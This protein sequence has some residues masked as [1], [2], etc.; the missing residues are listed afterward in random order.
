M[1][2]PTSTA[3][4]AHCDVV[5]SKIPRKTTSKGGAEPPPHMRDKNQRRVWLYRTLFQEQPTTAVPLLWPRICDASS[6]LESAQ[7]ANKWGFHTPQTQTHSLVHHERHKNLK[8]FF[9]AKSSRPLRH[10][11]SSPCGKN[12]RKT[13]SCYPNYTRYTPFDGPTITPAP[14]SLQ[15]MSRTYNHIYVVLLEAFRTAN[16]KRTLVQ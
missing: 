3:G 6:V 11:Q 1:C 9:P 5:V 12:I 15:N 4:K 2:L 16:K 13:Q 10:A 14:L 7:V 8:H